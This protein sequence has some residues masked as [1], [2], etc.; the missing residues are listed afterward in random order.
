MSASLSHLRTVPAPTGVDAQ[1]EP[2]YYSYRNAIEIAQMELPPLLVAWAGIPLVGGYIA[3]IIGP[4]SIGKSRLMLTVAVMQILQRPFPNEEY[5]GNA[6][7]LTWLFFGTENSIRRWQSDLRKILPTLNTEEQELLREHLFLPTLEHAADSYMRL[8]DE[9]NIEKCGETVRRV[10]PDIIVFD[11]WGDLCAEE[12]RDEVQRDTVRKI[13]QIARRGSNPN[14]P[15]IILN[16]SRMGAKAY[17]N[18][19]TDGG[20]YGRNSKAIFG[21]C[22]AVFNLRPV[23]TEQ[24]RFGDAIEII[25]A[26]HNDR[27]GF[28]PVA[29]ELDSSTMLYHALVN[30]DHDAVQAA[31][32]AMAKGNTKSGISKAEQGTEREAARAAKAEKERAQL[33]SAL[34][35]LFKELPGYWDSTT[36]KARLMERSGLSKQAVETYI[37]N[38]VADWKNNVGEGLKIAEQRQLVWDPKTCKVKEGTAH[39]KCKLLKGSPEAISRYVEEF[40]NRH[41]KA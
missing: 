13:R 8:D 31:W 28:A 7:P 27:K 9:A 36:F 11:P 30:F 32:E 35:D 15:T 25:D 3:E 12:L 37:A 33:D 22:R 21:Q 24:E 19:T 1:G 17:A 41:A 34:S 2:P 39:S 20:N 23:Y 10:S 16:H 26:K 6:G 18:A 5:A 40:K 4:P 38:R 14:V 29:I